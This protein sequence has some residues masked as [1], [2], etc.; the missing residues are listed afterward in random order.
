[1]SEVLLCCGH[2]T[3]DRV[4]RYLEGWVADR[5]IG[6]IVDVFRVKF[7][8]AHPQSQQHGH[9]LKRDVPSDQP[10]PPNH[11]ALEHNR[12]YHAVAYM[13]HPIRT[14]RATLYHSRMQS[15]V[16]LHILHPALCTL[17]HGL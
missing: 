15:A 8:E 1:M 3:R 9:N 16:G 10:I 13:S 4:P 6:L 5:S 2:P 11:H 17:N 7:G 12:K 14:R